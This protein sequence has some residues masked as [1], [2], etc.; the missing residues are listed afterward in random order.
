MNTSEDVDASINDLSCYAG[1]GRKAAQDTF[2][3]KSVASSKK[4]Q[5]FF[6]QELATSSNSYVEAAC[7]ADTYFVRRSCSLSVNCLRIL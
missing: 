7:D 1:H 6:Q 4:F 5:T 3:N 2:C